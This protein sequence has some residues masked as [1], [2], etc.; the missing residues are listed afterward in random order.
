MPPPRKKPP[1]SP[2]HAA[3]GESIR[4]RRKELGLTQEQLAERNYWEGPKIG[5]IERGDGNP[6]LSTLAEVS[7]A[8]EQDLGELFSHADRIRREGLPGPPRD[9]PDSA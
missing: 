2:L 3:F 5:E 9:D 6:R 8:L 7:K 1:R 4:R